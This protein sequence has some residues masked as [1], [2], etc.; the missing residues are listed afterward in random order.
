[1]EINIFH[2]KHFPIR[3][4]INRVN[5]QIISDSVQCGASICNDTLVPTVNEHQD[6]CGME[7]LVH[8]VM[9]ISMVRNRYQR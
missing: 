3:T 7:N 5:G 8:Q 2:L 9:K 4:M 6:R 1:M